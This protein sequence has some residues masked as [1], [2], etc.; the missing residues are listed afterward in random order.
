M[1]KERKNYGAKTTIYVWEPI[2][3]QAN[4]F[5]LLMASLELSNSSNGVRVLYANWLFVYFLRKPFI[6]N[7]LCR[8][9]IIQA[10]Y[11]VTALIILN[12]KVETF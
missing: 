8:N 7:I 12:F 1:L 3:Q 6:T 9:S 2:I 10:L 5:Y 11:Q 4:D